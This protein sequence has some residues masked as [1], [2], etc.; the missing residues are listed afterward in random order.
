MFV[1]LISV[2]FKWYNKNI[3]SINIYSINIY[4][5][6]IIL[7]IKWYYKN[8]NGFNKYCI[9]IKIIWRF[10]QELN[11]IVVSLIPN[12]KPDDRIEVFEYLLESKTPSSVSA[13]N[14][15]RVFWL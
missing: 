13:V 14:L 8:I 4:G 6:N 15:W 7:T 5:I 3:Y 2:I 1:Y 10:V 12:S 9:N 11:T